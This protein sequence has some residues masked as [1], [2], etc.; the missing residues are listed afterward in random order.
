MELLI[1]QF[2]LFVFLENVSIL[3]LALS[4][5]KGLNKWVFS[6]KKRISNSSKKDAV[7]HSGHK[8]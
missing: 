1:F 5:V 2:Q 3:D 4:G 6:K 8:S 7:S